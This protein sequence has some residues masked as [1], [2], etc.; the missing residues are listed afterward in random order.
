MHWENFGL[1]V[2]IWEPVISNAGWTV[3]INLHTFNDKKFEIDSTS[4]KKVE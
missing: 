1:I 3:K 4:C 2:L